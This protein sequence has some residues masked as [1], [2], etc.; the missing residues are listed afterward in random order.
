MV[1]F[2]R[3]EQ[4]I[5]NQDVAAFDRKDVARCLKALHLEINSGE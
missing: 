4:K 2:Q 5:A 1:H 3:P